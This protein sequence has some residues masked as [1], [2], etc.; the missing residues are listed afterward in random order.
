MLAAV[1]RLGTL[2]VTLESA[3]PQERHPTSLS[4]GFLTCET[5]PLIVPLS[6]H[7][8]KEHGG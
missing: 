6:Q 5:L 4:P 2:A 7:C 1:A 8:Y 3:G